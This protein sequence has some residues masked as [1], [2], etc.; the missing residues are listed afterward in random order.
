MPPIEMHRNEESIKMPETGDL[1][2][3]MQRLTVADE[4]YI[5]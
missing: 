3:A 4:M 5:R 2:I 1:N